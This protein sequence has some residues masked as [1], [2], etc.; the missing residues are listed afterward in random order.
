M[1]KKIVVVE[2]DQDLAELMKLSLHE[3]GMKVYHADDGVAGL[4]LIRK[5]L[6]DAVLL[7]IM[8]P[9]MNGYEV[10]AA[11]QSDERTRHIPIMV[12]TALTE[13]DGREKDETWRSRL[14]VADFISKPF[15][16]EELVCRVKKMLESE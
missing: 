13:D 12:L 3:E 2:D 8:M 7:D 4:E 16:V 1:S 14:N 5:R 6:P 15:S 9:R 10:C 11:L